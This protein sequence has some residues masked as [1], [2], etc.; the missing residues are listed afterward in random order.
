LPYVFGHFTADG[1]LG[2]TYTDRDRALSETVVGYWTNFAKTGNPNGPG[3]PTWPRQDAETRSYLRI[4]QAL[5]GGAQ[6]A[7]N[8]RRAQCDLAEQAIARN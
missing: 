5:P 4:S 2:S 6:A 1:T 7:Q 3:L 8:L